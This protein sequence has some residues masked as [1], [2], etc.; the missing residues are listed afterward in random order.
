MLLKIKTFEIII[1]SIVVLIK[2]IPLWAYLLLFGFVTFYSLEI[3]IAN[4]L[5]WYM[6]S[7]LNIYQ[8]KGYV[9]MD[10]SAI[11]HRGPLFPLMISLS[12]WLLGPSPWSAFWVIRIFCVI[13]PIMIYFLGKKLFDKWIGFSAA[14]LILTSYSLNYWSYRHIDTVWPF[15]VLLSICLLVKGLEKQKVFFFVL[16]GIFL[17]ISY[18]I[19][20]PAI[21]FLPLPLILL[22]LFA[23]NRT[24]KNALGVFLF[25]LV[26]ILIV[27]PWILYVFNE[28]NNLKFSIIGVGAD[29]FMT[30]TSN[31][32]VSSFLFNY[33]DGFLK[34]FIG[35]SNSIFSNFSLAPIFIISWIYTGYK[36]LKREK[37]SA[38]L[39]VCFVLLIPYIIIV[40]SENLRVG[41]LVIFILLTYLV[42][43]NFIVASV[44]LV[45]SILKEK[46]A[47]LRK[48][49][50]LFLAVPAI[51]LIL[52]QTFI[53]FKRDKSNIEFIKKSYM[54]QYINGNSDYMVRRLFNSIEKECGEWVKSNIEPGTNLMVSKGLE[55]EGIYFYA[56]GNYP[57]Y[58]MP[59]V[60]SNKTYENFKRGR[61]LIF[62]ASN[63]K[64][65]KYPLTKIYALAEID[66]F[67]SI[68][69]NKIDYIIV[70]KRRNYL[71]LYFD[72]NENFEKINDF[73]EGKIKIFKVLNSKKINNNF[74]T[75]VSNEIVIYL[76]DLNKNNIYKF[77]QLKTDFLYNILG[78]NQSKVNALMNLMEDRSNKNYLWVKERKIY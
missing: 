51:I 73:R 64:D 44:E 54:Y 65:Y 78:L 76:N 35:Q 36:A 1:P 27:M 30:K 55:G 61:K 66:L 17:A 60:E 62:L 42:T 28:T 6:N 13:S 48:N 21:L 33:L 24:R 23:Q 15:F 16:S 18:L 67:R 69:N 9:S 31:T 57:V 41:Q 50:H 34:Y 49:G 4:D 40:G 2:K 47:I 74:C 71:S 22:G 11:L 70:N 59:V 77:N 3:S 14:L 56:G 20:Q 75:L 45:C 39:F 68:S 53:P 19:K 29:G 38:I 5:G 63:S 10:G 26:T 52:I 32:A 25:F 8:G 43:A 12:Y 58:V 7:A 37:N 46:I 72:N